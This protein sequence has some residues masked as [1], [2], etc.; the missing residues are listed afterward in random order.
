[1]GVMTSKIMVGDVSYTVYSEGQGPAVVLLHGYAETAQMWFPLME[2]WKS[3]YRVIAPDLRGIGETS[4]AAGGYDKKSVAVDIKAILDYEDVTRAVIIGHDIGLMVAYAFA[5]QFPQM[6]ERLVLMDAFLPGI[7]PGN[8]IYNSPS[9]WHFRFN[10]PYAEKLVAGRERVFFD[11]LW[12]GFAAHPERFDETLRDRY[13]ALYVRPGR[14]RAGWEYFKAMP[15][16]AKDNARFLKTKLKM[17]VLGIGGE[18]SLGQAMELTVREIAEK[19]FSKVI[20]DCGHW[21][22]EECGARTIE[23]LEE[24]LNQGARGAVAA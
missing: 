14:M 12:D 21:M 10:G 13:A 20:P 15:Q 6:T 2:H 11:S 7:G 9:I 5:A 23:A 18:K 24:F 19:P 3:K 1:M 8:E 22:M 16:D 17:P 4:I